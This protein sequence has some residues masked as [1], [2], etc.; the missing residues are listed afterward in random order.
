[1]G[2]H[3]RVTRFISQLAGLH[4]PCSTSKQTLLYR[5]R[6][7]KV[8]EGERRVWGRS[9]KP[10]RAGFVTKGR[11]SNSISF[12]QNVKQLVLQFTTIV[13]VGYFTLNV[14]AWKLHLK[15]YCA[16]QQQKTVPRLFFMK[17]I[18][19]ATQRLS[20]YTYLGQRDASKK[21]YFSVCG[22]VYSLFFPFP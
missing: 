7:A 9:R 5:W 17:F 10:S 2:Q 20:Y 14:S 13:V 3:D 19:D 12:E 11:F 6:W 1:M 4:T 22:N 21:V 8:S 15:V 18:S 16:A